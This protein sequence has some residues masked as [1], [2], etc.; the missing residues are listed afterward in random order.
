M[1]KKTPETFRNFEEVSLGWVFLVAQLV[2]TLPAMWE[3]WVWSLGWEDPLEMGMA[4]HSSTLAWRIP[5][6][7]EPGGLQSMG[8]Q[9]VGHDERGGLVRQESACQ[10]GDVGSIPGLG[11][12]PRDANGKPLQYSCLESP[13]DRGAQWAT[14]H[15]VAKSQTRPSNF[16]HSLT[17]EDKQKITV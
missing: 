13:T 7:E 5:W 10:A 12:S 4:I 11:R 9:R 16:T 8:S 2:K 1:R 14:V 3:T 15:G 6:M 17:Q